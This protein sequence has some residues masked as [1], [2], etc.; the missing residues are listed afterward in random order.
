MYFL[1]VL[2]GGE[3]ALDRF[4]PVAV[5]VERI[6]LGLQGEGRFTMAAGKE[7]LYLAAWEGHAGRWL[8]PWEQ[9]ELASWKDAEGITIDGLEVQA[10]ARKQ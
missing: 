5:K 4:D 3:A 10:E 2:A 7:G 8:V 6:G 9:L 1:V